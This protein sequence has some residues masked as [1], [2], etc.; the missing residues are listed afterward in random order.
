MLNCFNEGFSDEDQGVTKATQ[1]VP[2]VT[3]NFTKAHLDPFD[4]SEQRDK[5][6]ELIRPI[7]IDV[8]ESNGQRDSSV[9]RRQHNSADKTLESPTKYQSLT[10]N[11]CTLIDHESYL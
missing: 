3:L 5:S 7:Q 11:C 8:E 9:K 1:M 6:L 4:I 2:R 10:D